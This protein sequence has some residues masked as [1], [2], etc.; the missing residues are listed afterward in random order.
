MEAGGIFPLDFQIEGRRMMGLYGG[1]GL[2]VLLRRG[3]LGLRV[4]I[5]GLL[6]SLL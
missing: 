3:I 6:M 5:G 1:A 4:W 2:S